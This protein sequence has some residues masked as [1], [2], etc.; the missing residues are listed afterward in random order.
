MEISN[1]DLARILGRLEAKLD[2][3]AQSSNRMEAALAG[4]DQKLTTRLDGHE[5]RLRDLEIANPKQIA[6]TVEQHAKR[7][8]TLEKNAAK[9]AAVAGVG[10][11]IGV[12]VIVE[13]IKRKM[14]M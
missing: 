14:G 4:L 13:Y 9:N 5:C 3:Q 11:S 1:D 10:A 6:E 2:S 12:A 8:A 7:I